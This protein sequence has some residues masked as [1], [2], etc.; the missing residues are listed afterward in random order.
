MVVVDNGEQAVQAVLS[1]REIAAVLMDVQ[2]PGMGGF[3]ATRQVRELEAELRRHVPIIAMT[4]H[5]MPDD[6]Q[7]C[8]DAGMDDYITKPIYYNALSD[9]LKK[10]LP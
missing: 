3:E 10:W 1:N 2:M 9:V 6:R 8:L 7:R 5:A 4:A